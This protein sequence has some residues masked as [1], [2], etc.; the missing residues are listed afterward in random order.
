MSLNAD[1]C[2]MLNFQG[3]QK[4]EVC[5]KEVKFEENQ[6]DLGLIVTQKMSWLEN[7]KR[8]VTKATKLLFFVKR[9]VSSKTSI[10]AKI[11]CYTGCVVPIL[12]YGSQSVYYNKSELK[13]IEKVQSRAMSWIYGY[14]S[15][16]VTKLKTVNLLPVPIY[17]ELPDILLLWKINCG[18][19][20][21]AAAQYVSW[22]TNQTTRQGNNNEFEVAKNRLC[23]SDE[24]FWKRQLCCITFSQKKL[25]F[26][27][28][29][30]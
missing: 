26:A 17:M 5:K 3:N 29:Q 12:T 23:K 19:Y 10:K 1:K 24:N 4:T 22:N 28:Q 13:I 2:N 25:T 8:R 27:T 18:N 30:I 11:N 16:Y 15:S 9:N 20:D 21:I 7:A 6:K 14:N